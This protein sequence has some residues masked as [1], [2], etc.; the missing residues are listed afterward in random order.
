[1]EAGVKGAE[2]GGSEMGLAT[3]LLNAFACDACTWPW[4][5]HFR[6]VCPSDEQRDRHRHFRGG[7]FWGGGTGVQEA[8][9]WKCPERARVQAQSTCACVVCDCVNGFWHNR[10]SKAVVFQLHQFRRPYLRHLWLQHQRLWAHP[11]NVYVDLT[12]T[13]GKEEQLN[14]Q[15]HEF[16]HPRRYL[17]CTLENVSQTIF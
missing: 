5:R 7:R 3:A 2:V 11:R 13:R 1:M 6:V 10:A 4:L 16:A 9:S 17:L 8:A 14:T 15:T 12:V